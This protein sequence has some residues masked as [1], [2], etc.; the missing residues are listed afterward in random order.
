MQYG[1]DAGAEV[2]DALESVGSIQQGAAA[3]LALMPHETV[4]DYEDILAR[5]QALPSAVEQ[6][7]ALLQDGLK[8]GYTPPKITC[9]TCRS[10]SRI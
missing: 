1:D 2:S 10:S 6:T 3:I 5:M 4:A 9:A 8:R 7:L